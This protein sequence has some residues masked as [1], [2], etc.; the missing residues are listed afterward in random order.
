[1][2]KELDVIGTII[3][4]HPYFEEQLAE[5]FTYFYLHRDRFMDSH[6]FL[7][8]FEI[9]R[10]KGYKIIGFETINKQKLNPFSADIK[11]EVL[12][13]I[14]WFNTQIQARFGRQAAKL[15]NIK[16]ALKKQSNLVLLDDGTY[17]IIPE[18]WIE[19]LRRY[20]AAAAAQEEE[21]L[22]FPKTD[23]YGLE[24]VF[25]PHMIDTE[26]KETLDE[27]KHKLLYHKELTNNFPPSEF[28]GELRNYQQIGLQ[29]LLQLD[30]FNFG[31]ILADDMGLGKSIQIIA[32][33]QALSAASKPSKPHP[34]QLLVV[35]TTLL[36]N[37]ISEFNK[38]A[39]NLQILDFQHAQRERHTDHFES[40]DV[41][42]S[43]YGSLVSDINFLKK[44]K[45]SY[46]F[47]DESQYLKN[48]DSLRYKAAAQ[49][50]SKGK[51]ALTGT[52]IENNSMD[53]YA[54]M[55]LVC[56]GLLGSKKYFKDVYSRPIDA[57]DDYKRRRS[58]QEKIKPF[59]L[60]RTKAEV[61]TEL[62]E[63]LEMIVYCELGPTQ[64]HIYEQYEREFRDFIDA[65]TGE[66]IRKSPMHILKGLMKL[67]Q[68]CNNPALISDDKNRFVSE[69]SKINYLV[70]QV[71]EKA[72]F[73]KIVIF[74]QFV[75]MLDNIKEALQLKGIKSLMLTGK[76]KNRANIIQ[77]FQENEQE[78][79]L[80]LSLKAGGT[81]LNLTA[82]SLLFLVDPWWNPAV[83]AQAIDRIYRIGQQ[84]A[85]TAVRLISPNTIE[86]KIMEL[87]KNKQFIASELI[88]SD[89]LKSQG[90]FSKETLN[91]IF[92]NT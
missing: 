74:S 85:V 92:T 75:S 18:E 59:I 32:F 89:Q 27:I 78:R 76:T 34:I 29:W 35:P 46:V 62:P 41:I 53:L 55:S 51:I 50:Q 73:Q 40:Y 52:P 45:F 8:T 16:A 9:W 43:S 67:R 57:F 11:V 23:I 10:Q 31:G 28:Q 20:F 1:M 4:Q 3:R 44:Y 64:R 72:I 15:K 13:G 88:L 65:H 58:L 26:V 14:N 33:I 37:W 24:E 30:H 63:K 82:A 54:Q 77:E 38:F 79:V 61:A 19:K 36:F 81:G 39:P 6:W 84:Q 47:F 68:I 80:L 86:E 71:E 91:Q 17:G 5:T 56:P 21:F 22:L 66:E 2:E 69:S 7:E 90:I 60:R 48:P 83:E 87:Q 42:I 49:L 25:E 70:E 12:S